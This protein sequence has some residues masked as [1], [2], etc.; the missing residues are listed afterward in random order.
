M[1]QPLLQLTSVTRSFGAVRSL[2]G[3]A[4]DLRP[5][6]SSQPGGLPDISRGLSVSDTPG[7]LPENEQHPGGVLELSARPNHIPS[8]LVIP[9]FWHPS[10][11]RM[12]HASRSGGVASLGSAQPPANLCEPSGFVPQ[13]YIQILNH[14]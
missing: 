5:G 13:H 4:L 9:H 12:I 3:M 1:V 14:T 8:P 10:W 7:I 6:A 11:V 2:K